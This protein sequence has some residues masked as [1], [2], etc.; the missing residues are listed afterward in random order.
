M[1]YVVLDCNQLLNNINKRQI[2]IPNII[3]SPNSY[4][5]SNIIIIVFCILAGNLDAALLTGVIVAGHG[6]MNSS[7]LSLVTSRN[8]SLPYP[9]LSPLFSRYSRDVPV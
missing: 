1:I 4:A 2:N 6:P 8:P 5:I 9:Q 3:Y 7:R